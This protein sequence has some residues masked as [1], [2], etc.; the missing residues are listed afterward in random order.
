MPALQFAALSL[1]AETVPIGTPLEVRLEQP[2]SSYSTRKGTHISA[3]LI[4][5]VSVGGEVILP[6]GTVL[7]GSVVS[8]RKVGLGVVHE[9]AQIELMLDRLVLPDGKTVPLSMQMTQVENARESVDKHGRVQG[10]RSSSTMS[11][12]A[13]GVVS[14]L[15]FGDPVAGFF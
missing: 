1:T 15:S 11:H 4:A 2:I 6:L 12:R 8:V 5:P 9:T 10:I 13:T 14:T 7:E 3:I